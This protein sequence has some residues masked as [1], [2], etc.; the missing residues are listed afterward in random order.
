MSRTVVGA[1]VLVVAGLSGCA[2]PARVIRQDPT[3]VVV[4]IPDNTN[5]WPFYYQDEALTAA[6]AYIQDPVLVSSHREKVGEQLTNTSDTTH[7]SF[8]DAVSSISTT[9]VSDRY[10]YHLEFRS[11]GPARSSTPGMPPPPIPGGP[12]ASLS[13]AGPTGMNTMKP[14]EIPPL[15]PVTPAASPATGLPSTALPGPGR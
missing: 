8:G 9:A 12:A 2:S 1:F 5:A 14:A 15:L 6:A 13:P 7:R 4:A 10:E 11:N 3:S